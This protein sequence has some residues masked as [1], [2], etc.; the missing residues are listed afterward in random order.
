MVSAGFLGLPFALFK[1]GSAVVTGL[2]GG[3]I[4]D[5]VSTENSPR[6][7]ASHAAG[8]RPGLWAGM[9]HA[10]DVLRTIWGWLAFGILVSAAITTWIPTESLAAVASWGPLGAS[11]AA[12]ALSL[13]LYVCA[14]ASVPIAAAFVAGGLPAGAALVFLMAG[15][16]TNVATMGAVFR[17]LGIERWLC[18]WAP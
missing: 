15:P 7:M 4:A 18:T 2:V 17:A 10:V 16:A 1:V 14:T 12:L 13:P 11:L 6:E 9:A 8:E 5:A 3:W